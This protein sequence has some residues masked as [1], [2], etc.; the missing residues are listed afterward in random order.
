MHASRN[1]L[2]RKPIRYPYKKQ[3]KTPI[4]LKILFEILTHTMLPSKIL[5]RISTPT[6]FAFPRISTFARIVFDILTR[7]RPE[8][9]PKNVNFFGTEGGGRDSLPRVLQAGE[10]GLQTLNIAR[11][12]CQASSLEG[13]RE[14]QGTVEDMPS[15]ITGERK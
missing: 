6:F 4:F 7:A 8:N 13:L 11:C 3:R 2:T 12:C 5:I 15:A 1:S 9:L 10:T 14:S